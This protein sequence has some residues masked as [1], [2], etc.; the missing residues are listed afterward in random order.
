MQRVPWLIFFQCFCVRCIYQFVA[1]LCIINV[2]IWAKCHP[3]VSRF[4][5]WILIHVSI[6]SSLIK[7]KGCKTLQ[8]A[9]TT[10]NSVMWRGWCRLSL[11]LM[12]LPLSLCGVR[13]HR[14]VSLLINI[15]IFLQVQ[16]LFWCTPLI[17]T[18]IWII[19]DWVDSFINELIIIH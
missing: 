19:E 14:S 6:S 1:Q 16:D 2:F 18:H 11:I 13:V 4:E 12:F 10:W 15:W 7:K 9:D 5:S 17:L 3:P 8:A